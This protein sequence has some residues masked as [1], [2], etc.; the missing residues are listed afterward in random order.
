MTAA[1]PSERAWSIEP[2]DFPHNGTPREVLAFLVRYAVLAPSG[3][4]TQPW[5]FVLS[6]THVDVVADKS[7]ALHMI[8]PHDREMIMSCAAA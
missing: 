3:H 2:S 5:R 7:R 8:D 6:N 1:L 4:N